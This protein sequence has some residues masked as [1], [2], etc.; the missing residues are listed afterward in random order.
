[1]PCS[2]TI[3]VQHDLCAL[4][5]LH[6]H[7]RAAPLHTRTRMP[8][9]QATAKKANKAE[10]VA[11]STVLTF[12]EALEQSEPR[13]AQDGDGKKNYAER[14]SNKLAVL[15]ANKLRDSGQFA[16]ILPTADGK[17]RESTS[18]GGAHKKAKKTDVK[19]ATSDAGLELLVSIKT[20]NFMDQ[21]KKTSGGQTTVSFSRYTRNMVRNDHELRAEAMDHHE[22][23]PFAVLVALFFLPI[24]ACDDGE[25]DKSSFAHAVMTFRPRAGRV[26]PSDPPQ[27]F[28]GFFIGLYDADGE[29]KGRV[30][31]FNVD[32]A[33]PRRGRPSAKLYT[34]DEVVA[35]IA[36]TYGIRNRRYMEWAD[37]ELPAT[38]IP[39]LD[40]APPLA[41]EIADDDD[42]GAESSERA[43]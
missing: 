39:R 13:P 36:K 23:H 37:E 27:L 38:T 28:E 40:D 34:L 21:H 6:V 9:R 12:A 26:K 30:Q 4:Q 11:I 29:H 3:A 17:G 41:S 42:E 10:R 24:S 15:V 33:P 22:R 7:D 43:F 14:L 32:D 8:P 2:I 1:M 16:G 25:N 18:T 31:F 19:Y 20:L 35:T 5:E